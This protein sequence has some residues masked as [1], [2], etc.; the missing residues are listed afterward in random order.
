MP[1]VRDRL[2]DM[3]CCG[4]D[5]DDRKS[6]MVRNGMVS[7]IKDKAKM[8]REQ[9][10]ECLWLLGCLTRAPKMQQRFIECSNWIA[11]YWLIRLNHK[12]KWD[13]QS[14]WRSTSNRCKHIHLDHFLFPVFLCKD[15]SKVDSQRHVMFLKSSFGSRSGWNGAP[16]LTFSA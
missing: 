7:G 12:I 14:F 3:G 15:C 4:D 2:F 11:T 13:P 9:L 6:H 1:K 10:L 5:Y 16:Q 8:R